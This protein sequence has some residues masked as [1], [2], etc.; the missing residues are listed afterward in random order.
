MPAPLVLT[1]QQ[2]QYLNS[3]W[4]KH[5]ISE[6][7]KETGLNL[8]FITKYYKPLGI[9][10]ITHR[11]RIANKVLDLY[12]EYSV[13]DMAI[14]CACSTTLINEIVKDFDLKVHTRVEL[15]HKNKPIIKMDSQ[16][17][18][19]KLISAHEKRVKSIKDNR[20]A[21]IYNQSGSALT[22]S[23]H[24]IKTTVRERTYLTN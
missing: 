12:E 14:E 7:G 10:P 1:E 18:I 23:L 17:E 15:R 11:D 20:P 13:E 24:G 9:Q 5:T 8:A 19:N 22:D 2:I 16:E 3:A 4:K 21:A 6:I